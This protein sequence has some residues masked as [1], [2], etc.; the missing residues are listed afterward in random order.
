MSTITNRMMKGSKIIKSSDDTSSHKNKSIE[1]IHNESTMNKINDHIK[2]SNLVNIIIHHYRHYYYYNGSIWEIRDAKI[3]T[4]EKKC[5]LEI[6]NDELKLHGIELPKNQNFNHFFREITDDEFSKN[7]ISFKNIIYN[8]QTNMLV[9]NDPSAIVLIK[10]PYEYSDTNFIRFL[11]NSYFIDLMIALYDIIRGTDHKYL[12]VYNNDKII[13]TIKTFTKNIVNFVNITHK[14]AKNDKKNNRVC[15]VDKLRD[16]IDYSS[17]YDDYKIICVEKLTDLLQLNDNDFPEMFTKIFT[18]FR[19]LYEDH[20]HSI[21]NIKTVKLFFSPSIVSFNNQI[22]NTRLK[23]N[24]NSYTSK[25]MFDSPPSINLNTYIYWTEN[26]KKKSFVLNDIRQ[27]IKVLSKNTKNCYRSKINKLQTFFE[28]EFSQDPIPLTLNILKD[29]FKTNHIAAISTQRG[30]CCAILNDERFINPKYKSLR[31]DLCIFNKN[32]LMQD[33]LNDGDNK[34]TEKIIKKYLSWGNIVTIHSHFKIYAETILDDFNNLIGV[35]KT[36]NINVFDSITLTKNIWN[37]LMLLSLYVLQPP[38]RI[39]DYSVIM[40]DDN[41][42][43]PNKCK[44]ISCDYNI[45]DISNENFSNVYVSQNVNNDFSNNYYVRKGDRHYFK[46]S[47]FKTVKQFG[48]QIIEVNDA[49]KAII[50]RTLEIRE[51]Y[52]KIKLE[53]NIKNTLDD[54]QDSQNYLFNMKDGAYAGRLRNIFENYAEKSTTVSI[55][56]HSRIDYELGLESTT[57]NMRQNLS[58]IMS[59]NMNTQLSYHKKYYDNV[60]HDID[61]ININKNAIKILEN[62]KWMIHRIDKIKRDNAKNNNAEIN[63]NDSDDNDSDD[64]DSDDNDINGN[65]NNIDDND[66][67]GNKN[68]DEHNT[69]DRNNDIKFDDNY[70]HDRHY[71]NNTGNNINE[72]FY[73]DRNYDIDDF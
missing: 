46:I 6:I 67:N 48:C 49:L 73:N 69:N 65:N 42:N 13:D 58:R 51:I 70:Y 12:L 2:T 72:H 56:R 32:L 40:I 62:K 29:F 33:N 11:D 22:E 36:Y 38:R 17:D 20:F 9:N 10:S 16:C 21:K 52:N 64:N 27:E 7:H 59:H 41:Q 3:N 19:L 55:L 61:L 37:D 63:D 45:I 25:N 71:H 35:Q 26:Q 8:T 54:A 68:Y 18:K 43:F 44:I 30:Y 5:V 14:A 60:D 47:L 50:T 28:K 4:N 24:I 1:I 57:K 34:P 53:L 15:Y 23:F 31:T 39:K 66:I